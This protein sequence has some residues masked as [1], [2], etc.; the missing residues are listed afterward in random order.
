V[1]AIPGT[2]RI[3]VDLEYSA[4]LQVPR[5][6]TT[7]CTAAEAQPVAAG[8]GDCV[9]VDDDNRVLW[10]ID[11]KFGRGDIVYA[12]EN[13]QL[14]L[15][16]AAAVARYEVLGVEDDWKVSMAIHQ[17]RAGHFDSEVITVAE[18]KAWVAAQV[19]KA[20]EAYTL[21]RSPHLI[22][23]RRFN[24]GEK[25]C[26]WCPLSGNCGAQNRKMLDRFPVNG[27]DAAM[28]GLHT[29]DAVQLG[30][31]LKHADEWDAYVSKLREVALARALAG[32]VIP[33]YK[34]VEGR[35]GNRTLDTTAH[36]TLPPEVQEELGVD[37]ATLPVEEALAL[38]AGDAAYK[39]RELKTVAQ[40]EKVLSKKAPALWAVIQE[41]IT[42][43]EGAPSLVRIEDPRPPVPV[44]TSEFP[45][46]E[47]AGADLL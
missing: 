21:W 32:E 7:D 47:T 43:K 40:L 41:H 22:S 29:L 30:E 45:L 31:A 28:Q 12:K 8:T 24:P 44:I 17:P 6:V 3:E 5:Y 1:R 35:R 16:G 46:A 37:D 34:V 13:P 38:A 18:L 15:Y 42:Q 14:R 4:L 11:L 39:P 25:Q 36:L 9:I 2:R 19:D 23:P 20:N 10:V 26:R 33:D 27:A